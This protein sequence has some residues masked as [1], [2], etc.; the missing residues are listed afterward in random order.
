MLLD[1]LDQDTSCFGNTATD[2]NN[3]RITTHAILDK[4]DPK[5]PQT[6]STKPSATASPLLASSN[7][8]FAVSS[9]KFLRLVSSLVLASF[10]FATRTIPVAEVYALNS[11][12]VPGTCLDLIM[13]YGDMSDLTA[14]TIKSCNDFSIYD[15]TAADTGSKCYHDNVFTAFCCTLPHLS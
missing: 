12:T 5:I 13:I 8:S 7:T 15:D 3:F 6:S 2:N 10:L 11:R 9:G 4:V 14:C 1:A